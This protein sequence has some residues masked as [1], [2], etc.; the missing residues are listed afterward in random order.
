[1]PPLFE[2]ANVGVLEWEVEGGA[3]MVRVENGREPHAIF[4]RPY[5]NTVHFVVCYMTDKPEVGRVN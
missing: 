4:Q 5:H 2:D 3:G 1:M